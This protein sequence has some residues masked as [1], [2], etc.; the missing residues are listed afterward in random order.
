MGLKVTVQIDTTVPS[1]G[2]IRVVNQS[3]TG[4][5]GPQG[6]QGATGATGPQG[7]QGDP[8]PA[9][10]GVATGGTQG[11][12]LTKVS[13]TNY[14]TTWSNPAARVIN[15]NGNPGYTIFVGTVDPV[16]SYTPATGDV[17]IKPV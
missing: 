17:W 15:T 6:Q 11:Q 10:A 3:V 4:P 2:R 7:P 1:G 5:Q 16:V 12:V 9:G 13:A 14:D 8:G